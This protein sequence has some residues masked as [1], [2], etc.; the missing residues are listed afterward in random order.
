MSQIN[1]FRALCASL[2]YTKRR[3]R[4][5]RQL[6]LAGKVGSQVKANTYCQT[7][8]PWAPHQMQFHFTLVE[9]RVTACNSQEQRKNSRVPRRELQ[10]IPLRNTYLWSELRS[11]GSCQE[12]DNSWNQRKQNNKTKIFLLIIPMEIVYLYKMLRGWVDFGSF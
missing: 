8:L 6:P 12:A 9:Q 2:K 10:V 3:S 5:S 1:S 7:R 11:L 4:L